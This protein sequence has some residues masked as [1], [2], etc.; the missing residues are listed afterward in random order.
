MLFGLPEVKIAETLTKSRDW[1]DVSLS[2]H[3]TISIL[4]MRGRD[5]SSK[6]D[7]PPDIIF[8][9]G[10]PDSSPASRKVETANLAGL[11][12]EA[13]VIGV[14]FPK[15]ADRKDGVTRTQT[16]LE[17][18][19]GDRFLRDWINRFEPD[20]VLSGHIH[21]APFYAPE[22]SWIDRIGKTWV[23]NPGRQPGSFPT[24]IVLDFAESVAEWITAEGESVR[25]LGLPDL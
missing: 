19:V 12:A 3:G 13:K 20:L 8:F 15:A 21:S 16:A 24:Y 18:T 6:I 10:E 23:F 4:Y 2:D 5:F 14:A 17:T 25:R 22:G 9:L 1:Q 7:F 11:D